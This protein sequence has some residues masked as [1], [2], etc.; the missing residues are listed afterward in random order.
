MEN[1]IGI[2]VRDTLFWLVGPVVWVGGRTHHAEVQGIVPRTRDFL[3]SSSLGTGHATQ[4]VR[5]GVGDCC[6]RC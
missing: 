2:V 4:I 5:N 3:T 1:V 6:C